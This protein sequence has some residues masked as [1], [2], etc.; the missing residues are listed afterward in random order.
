MGSS[1]K[2]SSRQPVT[3]DPTTRLLSVGVHSTVVPDVAGSNEAMLRGYLAVVAMARGTAVASLTEVRQ[4]DVVVL[5]QLLDLDDNDLEA[6]FIR[7]LGMTP[8]MA[9]DTRRRIAMHRAVLAA[10]GITVG[11]LMTSASASGMPVGPASSVAPIVVSVAAA[12]STASHIITVSTERPAPAPTST[13][14]TTAPAEPAP[15][16]TAPPDYDP[17]EVQIGDAMVIERGTQSDDPDT[18]VGDTVTYSR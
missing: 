14:S 17:N 13:T 4:H 3:F 18:Q 11:A 15:A 6:R 7:L 8:A 10:A 9:A 1:A 2:A 12:A 5:A 16:Q